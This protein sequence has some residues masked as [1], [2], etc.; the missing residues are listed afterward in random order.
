MEVGDLTDLAGTTAV[1]LQAV[2]AALSRD[3]VLFA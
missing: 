1:C 3:A 2:G